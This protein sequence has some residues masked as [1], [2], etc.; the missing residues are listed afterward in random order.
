[1][2]RSCVNCFCEG[3]GVSMGGSDSE[4]EVSSR[5]EKEGRG[6]RSHARR[7]T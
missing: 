3:K 6:G 7:K 1:M 5:E 2:I 4:R